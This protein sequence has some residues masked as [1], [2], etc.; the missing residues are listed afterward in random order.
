M[1]NVRGGLHQQRGPNLI[2]TTNSINIT[3]KIETNTINETKNNIVI[4]ILKK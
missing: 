3:I 2:V 4:N 1:E